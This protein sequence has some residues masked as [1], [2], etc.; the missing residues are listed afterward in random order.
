LSGHSGEPRSAADSA[1]YSA[2]AALLWHFSSWELGRLHRERDLAPADILKQSVYEDVVI[3]MADLCS[4]SSYVRDT[5]DPRQIR[6][7]LSEFYSLARH[8]V[9]NAG[10]MLYQFVGDEVVALFGIY[11]PAPSAASKTLRCIRSLFNAGNAVSHAWQRNLDRLQPSRGVHIGIAAG[12]L[13]VLPL[14]PFSHSHIGF[15]GD[16]LNM[17]ARLMMQAAS[18]QVVV[19][20]GFYSLL[21][22][23]NQALFEEIEPIDAKNVGRIRA[24]RTTQD[25]L[26]AADGRG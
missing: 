15:I 23:A 10:G 13:N 19:S 9:L 12:H 14:R 22:T 16:G 18:S 11:E 20:N 21:D 24:F 26:A 25:L 17:A 8:A 2:A 5:R 4:F 7:R 3:V 1:T 6:R